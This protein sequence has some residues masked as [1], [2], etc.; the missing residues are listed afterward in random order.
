M[1]AV[2]N[3]QDLLRISVANA[4]NDHR[5]GKHE[6]PPAIISIF[7]GDEILGLLYAV[8]EDRD[9]SKYVTI[10][11]NQEKLQEFLNSYRKTI[12]YDKINY[13]NYFKSQIKLI[14]PLIIMKDLY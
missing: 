12:K 2:D 11:L 8:A 5:L 6:A 14:L 10:F 9:Y 4:D 13:L 7:I 3:H 1:R